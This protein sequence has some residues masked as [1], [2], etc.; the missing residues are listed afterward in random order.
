MKRFF[1]CL[2]FFLFL[3]SF[4]A[5][6]FSAVTTNSS[7]ASTKQPSRLRKAKEAVKRKAA[8]LKQAAKNKGAALKSFITRNPKAV[9]G[10][11]ALTTGLIAGSVT[12]AVLVKKH[13]DQ[14]KNESSTQTTQ[15]SS[16]STN[17]IIQ[18]TNVP[19][20][21]IQKLND[22]AITFWPLVASPKFAQSSQ[23]K[24]LLSGFTIQ[25]NTSLNTYLSESG[26]ISLK[27]DELLK[28][29]LNAAFASKNIT[30]PLFP[31]EKLALLEAFLTD[32]IKN[33]NIDCSQMRYI[34]RFF[35]IV[36]HDTDLPLNSSNFDYYKTLNVQYTAT[37]Q[38]LDFM[39]SFSSCLMNSQDATLY[40]SFPKIAEVL[41]IN[42]SSQPY[43]AAVNQDKAMLSQIFSGN[44][45]EDLLAMKEFAETAKNHASLSDAVKQGLG[46]T[47]FVCETALATIF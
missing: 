22:I 45:K 1:S 43:V 35:S 25:S 29:T 38:E 30:L 47:V 19:N 17:Q 18:V 4:T 5:N 36:L 40:S 12:T 42:A 44:T 20:L 11:A 2:Y 32:V 24:K 27:S 26:L 46:R 3:T 9:A 37:S 15:S 16:T 41:A 6:V 8:A 23:L 39:I 28:A 7:P 14:K 31:L 21:E 34:L 33:I 10:V 13:L